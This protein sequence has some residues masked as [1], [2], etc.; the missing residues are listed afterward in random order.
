MGHSDLPFVVVHECWIYGTSTT[1]THASGCQYVVLGPLYSN[2]VAW[3]DI[4]SDRRKDNPLFVN[5]S[6]V[7]C[8]YS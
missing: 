4:V 6:L 5:E 3:R 8:N 2:L 1:N 7:V